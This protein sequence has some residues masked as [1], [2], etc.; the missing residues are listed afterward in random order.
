MVNCLHKNKKVIEKPSGKGV[1]A[2]ASVRVKD[3]FDDPNE[4]V[5]ARR[6]FSTKSGI[7]FDNKT[8]SIDFE[9]IANLKDGDES[10][11]IMGQ[12][13]AE[14]KMERNYHKIIASYWK[15]RSEELTKMQEE[16]NKKYNAC[17]N[18]AN[19]ID[20]HIINIASDTSIGNNIGEEE[21]IEEAPDNEFIDTEMYV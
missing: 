7:S 14:S 2:R 15:H 4:A 20:T 17:L 18:T 21:I 19:A 3:M 5:R 12:R 11:P 16:V 13:I 10:N 6:F 9:G 1:V 8:G